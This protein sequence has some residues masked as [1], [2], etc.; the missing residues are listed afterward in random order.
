MTREMLI[1]IKAVSRGAKDSFIIC[2]MP[3]MSYNVSI[4]DGIKNCGEM[5]RAGANAVKIEGCNDY[6]LSLI[7]RLTDSGIPVL[8]HLGYTPQSINTLGGHSIQGKD[9]DSINNILAQAHSLEKAG[10]FAL[11]SLTLLGESDKISTSILKK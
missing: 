6:L 8:G 3:F 4:E 7:K 11:F 9:D 5:L 1:F 10:V 2:D